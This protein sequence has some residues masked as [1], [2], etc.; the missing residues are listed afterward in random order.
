MP[1][2]GP[3]GPLS[4]QDGQLMLQGNQLKFQRGAAVK[5]EGEDRNSGGESSPC[6]DGTAGPR[7]SPAF[8]RL[9]EI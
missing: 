5:T 6:R 3:T 7:K 1:Q 2:E 9:V 8:L 4:A